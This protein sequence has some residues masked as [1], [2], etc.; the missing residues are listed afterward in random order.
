M[1]DRILEDPNCVWESVERRLLN[2]ENM[3]REVHESV[4]EGANGRGAIRPGPVDLGA[5]LSDPCS[6]HGTHPIG[7]CGGQK[8]R[9]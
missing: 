8:R 7:T 1:S 4:E 2:V 6:K 9:G 5:R 3:L